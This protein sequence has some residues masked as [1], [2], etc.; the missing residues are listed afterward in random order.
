MLNQ[1]PARPNLDELT[2]PTLKRRPHRTRGK[3]TVTGAGQQDPISV[4]HLLR[5]PRIQLIAQLCRE[6][7]RLQ[8]LGHRMSNSVGKIVRMARGH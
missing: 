1:K 5:Q 2:S 7:P 3:K 6:A 4:R 8:A